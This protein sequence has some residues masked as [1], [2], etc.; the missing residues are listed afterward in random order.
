LEYLAGS[1]DPHPH[2]LGGCSRH[3]IIVS[4]EISSVGK[5]VE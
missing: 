3:R 2:T 1:Q 4:A 5:L